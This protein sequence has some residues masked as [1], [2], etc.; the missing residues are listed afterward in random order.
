MKTLRECVVEAREKKTAIGHFNISNVETLRAIFGAARKLEQPVIIGVSEGERDFLGVRQAAA[1]VRSMREEFD[2]PI[3]LNAD[4]TYSLDRVKEAVDTGFDAVIFD[5]ARLSFEEN[6]QVARECVNYARQKNPEIVVEG[7]LG[8]IGVSSKLLDE[9][10]AG[11]ALGDNLTK[12]EDAARFV[13][14]TG[15][16]LLAP[17][18]GNIH[19]MLKRRPDPALDIG[20]VREIAAA[21][22]VPLVLHGASG[23]QDEEVQAA[24]AAGVAIVHVNTELRVAYRDALKIS[25]QENPEETTPYKIIKPVIAAVEAV[26]EKKLRLFTSR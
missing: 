15:V 17:A 8:Y 5:G 12:P 10:P 7:E 11:A 22:A 25:L 23:N 14:A 13:A 1:L 9:V 4:H 16:D 3:F 24:I 2:Y 26:V 20:R 6:V 19:G 21:A 18:I